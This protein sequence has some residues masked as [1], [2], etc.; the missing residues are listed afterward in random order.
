VHD[1]VHDFA[2]DLHVHNQVDVLPVEAPTTREE[3]R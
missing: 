2:P 3:I 1:V